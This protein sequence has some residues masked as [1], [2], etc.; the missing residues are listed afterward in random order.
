MT[1]EDL[2]IFVA[3]AEAGSMSELARSMKRTQPAVAQHLRRLEGELGASLVNRTR[4]GITLTEAGTALYE[5]TTAALSALSTAKAEIEMIRGD[6]E[7]RLAIAASSG[8]ARH[9][10]MPAIKAL[11]RNR[12]NVDFRLACS[13]T[14]EQQLDAIRERRADLAF[15]ALWRDTPGFQYR[16]K[17][18][19]PYMLLVHRDDPLAQRQ[20]IDLKQVSATRFIA[21][22]EQSRTSQF[23][24]EQLADRGGQLSVA[25]TVDTEGTA[26]LYVELGLGHAILSAVQ[27]AAVAKR[28]DLRALPIRGLPPMPLGW[29]ARDFGLLSTTA[30]EFLSLF[31]RRVVGRLHA[32]AG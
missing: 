30:R 22:G 13:N 29:A 12:P 8:T 28:S 24:S 4:R 23:I 19:M 15:V 16:A 14:L 26:I 27:A 31:D 3:A 17:L 9:T 32:I 2:R 25:H 18:E 5:R 21:I 7:G 10:L 1:L 11:R 6:S 20:R